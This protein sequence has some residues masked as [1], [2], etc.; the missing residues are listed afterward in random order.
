LRHELGYADEPL[1]ICSIGGTSV[2]IELLD[3]CGQAFEIVKQK[4][5]NLRMILVSGPRLAAESLSVPSGVEVREYV[6]VLY[7]HFAASD[8]AIVQGG[9][10]TTLELT[11]LNCPFIYF[12]LEAHYEQQFHVS[13]RLKRH[14]AGIRLSYSQ[15]KAE[16]L[17]KAIT[18]NLGKPV[19]YLSISLDGAFRTAQLVKKM[20]E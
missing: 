16:T 11:A 6:P 4:I 18:D 7:K 17:A 20:I 5:A 13:H 1:V 3:L 2:G 10:T 14:R 8:L 12:P 15:V 19:D 9:G